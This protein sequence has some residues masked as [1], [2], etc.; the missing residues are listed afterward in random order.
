VIDLDRVQTTMRHLVAW[1]NDNGFQTTDSGDGVTNVEAGMEGA[2]SFPHV[3]IAVSPE[4]LVSE[5]QRLRHL[6]VDLGVPVSA[7][8]ADP[9]VPCIQAS[10]DPCAVEGASAVLGL[11]GLSDATFQCNKDLRG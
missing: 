4:N 10:Y 11:M 6:L 7:M 5:A 3:W 2:A 1:L 8:G 9:T